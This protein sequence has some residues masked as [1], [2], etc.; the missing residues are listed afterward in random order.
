MLLIYLRNAACDKS[1]L[2]NCRKE[3]YCCVGIIKIK[4]LCW[5]I[6]NMLCLRLLKK[7]IL[8]GRYLCLKYYYE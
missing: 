4:M 5:A 8:K 3:K 1:D 7:T 6:K 2:R